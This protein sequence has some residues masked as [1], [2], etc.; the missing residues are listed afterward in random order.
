MNYTRCQHLK[1]ATITPSLSIG[2]TLTFVVCCHCD[3]QGLVASISHLTTFLAR[4]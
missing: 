1:E 3:Y 2:L 4:I